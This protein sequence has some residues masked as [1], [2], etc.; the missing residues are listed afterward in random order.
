MRIR[1]V[2]S[3]G[4]AGLRRE[5]V[6]ETDRLPRERRN[7]LEELIATATFFA[8]PAR[9]VSGLPD[10]IQYRVEVRDAARAH[11]VAFDDE[12]GNEDL[13]SLVACVFEAEAER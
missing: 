6:V 12:C 8:L 13:R 9:L 1:V 4:L 2:E 5:R 11:V 3:G 7:V 10:V